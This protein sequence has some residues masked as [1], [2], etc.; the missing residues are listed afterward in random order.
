MK[1]YDRTIELY[2]C[3]VL[4]HA[5]KYTIYLRTGEFREALESYGEI[6]A[7]SPHSALAH[8]YKAKIH[9]ALDEVDEAIFHYT[10][11]IMIK[12]ENEDTVFFLYDDPYTEREQLL[13]SRR[14]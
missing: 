3:D 9:V 7:H 12:E 4:A 5:G 11:A 14:I 1:D 10:Q 8:L 2:P 6:L 13:R